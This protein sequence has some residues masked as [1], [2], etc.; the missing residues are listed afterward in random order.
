[1]FSNAALT[2]VTL[3]IIMISFILGN[4]EKKYVS[5]LVH[6]IVFVDIPYFDFTYKGLVRTLQNFAMS[7]TFLYVNVLFG[8]IYKYFK[9]LKEY[10]KYLSDCIHSFYSYF[11]RYLNIDYRDLNNKLDLA[12]FEKYC[13]IRSNG[14]NN[15]QFEYINGKDILIEGAGII[16]VRTVQPYYEP[17]PK[18]Y[19]EYTHLKKYLE[20]IKNNLDKL[21]IFPINEELLYQSR[22]LIG[23]LHKHIEG[24]VKVQDNSFILNPNIIMADMKDSSCY[25][26]KS[27]SLPNEQMY[28]VFQIIR[29]EYLSVPIDPSDN[30]PHIGL[31]KMLNLRVEK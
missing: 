10:K 17:I 8:S 18:T 31:H 13:K 11:G 21:S 29:K 14:S 12:V 22:L 20:D 24:L 9:R 2:Y 27:F 26:I 7:I 19:V 16:S 28:R 30:N 6:K 15:H 5:H 3:A 1:M 23:D 4:L 25:Y